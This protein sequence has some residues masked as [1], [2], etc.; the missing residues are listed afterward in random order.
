MSMKKNRWHTIFVKDGGDGRGR[1]AEQSPGAGRYPAPLLPHYAEVARIIQ[2]GELGPVHFV[3]I[4]NY[5][6]QFPEGF[7]RKADSSAP[8]G[9]DWDFYLGPSRQGAV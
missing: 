6:N 8:D 9:L 5:A 3:R 2:S 1:A 7:G 4:W